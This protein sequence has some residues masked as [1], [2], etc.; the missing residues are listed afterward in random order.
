MLTKGLLLGHICRHRLSAH[1]GN[2]NWL[3]TIN[4]HSNYEWLITGHHFHILKIAEEV[5]EIEGFCRIF[6]LQVLLIGDAF[7]R[8]ICGPSKGLN[9]PT[10]VLSTSQNRNKLGAPGISTRYARQAG[11]QDHLYKALGIQFLSKFRINDV[12]FR[13]QLFCQSKSAQIL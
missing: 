9:F 7:C 6:F 1:F 4:Y 10:K 13:T 5:P 8:F 12:G 11:R 3:R 2:G